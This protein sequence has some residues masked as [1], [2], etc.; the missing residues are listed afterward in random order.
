[1]IERPWLG[2]RIGA[3]LQVHASLQRA[4][5]RSYLPAWPQLRLG[6]RLICQT[7]RL[8]NGY[9]PGQYYHGTSSQAEAPARLMARKA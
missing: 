2:E 7:G 8:R 4:V 1:M 5:Q 9:L 6:H 3:G